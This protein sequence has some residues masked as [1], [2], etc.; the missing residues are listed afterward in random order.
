M[1]CS[2]KNE[3]ISIM[4]KFL[5]KAKISWIAFWTITQGSNKNRV[6]NRVNLSIKQ[7]YTYA[8]YQ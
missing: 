2:L 6:F 8:A 1:A 7:K 4:A 3:N 5:K